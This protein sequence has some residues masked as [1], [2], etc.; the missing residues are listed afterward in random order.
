MP[1]QLI[2]NTNVYFICARNFVFAGEKYTMGQEFDQDLSVGRI[3][4]LVRTRYLYP[5][6][7]NI[8]DKPRHWHHHIHLRSTL[9]EK[10]GLG[11]SLY[12]KPER[13][14]NTKPTK[15]EAREAEE[16]SGEYD[17]AAHSVAE[18]QEYLASADEDEQLRVLEA[19]ESGKARKGI[20][21]G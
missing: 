17:P 16:E 14:E 8:E 1:S 21:N 5:V 3:D 10:L 12:N 20:L 7:D 9:E 15:A 4:Q 18:V 19:E 2:T 11:E 13:V 6:V